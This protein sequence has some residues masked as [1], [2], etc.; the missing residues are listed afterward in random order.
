MKER[1]EELQVTFLHQTDRAILVNITGDL[2][3]GIW[4]PKSQI[5]IDWE[6]KE[7]ARG[8]TITIVAPEWL[9]LAKELL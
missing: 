6:G 8:A 3:T 1:L 7:P 2:K 9:L 4:L 5:E